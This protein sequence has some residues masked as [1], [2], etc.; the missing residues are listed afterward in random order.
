MPVNSKSTGAGAYLQTPPTRGEPT[1]F[2]SSVSITWW[3]C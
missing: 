3:A 2:P 1:F